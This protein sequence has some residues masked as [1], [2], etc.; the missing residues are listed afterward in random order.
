VRWFPPFHVAKRE[1]RFL[2]YDKIIRC[3]VP[4]S[5]LEDDRSHRSALAIDRECHC[6]NQARERKKKRFD[7]KGRNCDFQ[8]SYFQLT[9]VF[10]SAS[11]SF[12][13]SHYSPPEI[14]RDSILQLNFMFGKPQEEEENKRN[15]HNR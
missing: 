14:S 13:P 8:V 12:T 15:R 6:Q 11:S 9:F 1:N 10:F 4:K 5:I 2:D 7:E 3:D